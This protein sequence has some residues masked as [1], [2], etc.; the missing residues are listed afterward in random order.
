MN[1]LKQIRSDAEFLYSLGIMDYSLLVGVHNREYEVRDEADVTPRL[2]RAS[3]RPDISSSVS[4]LSVNSKGRSTGPNSMVGNNNNGSIVEDSKFSPSL[5]SID[6]TR[7]GSDRKQS[8]VMEMAVV[9]P[10]DVNTRTSHLNREST[11]TV[12][13]TDLHEPDLALTQRLEVRFLRLSFHFVTSSNYLT[14]T[15]GL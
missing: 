9:R 12:D 13:V 6:E 15:L 4:K 2:T 5:A 7:S 8:N 14:L 11:E 10:I 3:T 1:L